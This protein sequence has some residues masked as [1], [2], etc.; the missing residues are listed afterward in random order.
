VA[1][2]LA[3]STPVGVVDITCLATGRP[4]WFMGSWWGPFAVGEGHVDVDFVE[5]NQDVQA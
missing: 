3:N 2:L 5:V 1:T 4:G